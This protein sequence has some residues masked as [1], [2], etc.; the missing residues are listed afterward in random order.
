[1]IKRLLL[2][3]CVFTFLSQ[4][5]VFAQGTSNKDHNFKVAKNLETFSAIYKYLD[6]MYVDT[7]NADEVIGNGINA[8]LSSLDPYTVYYPEDK[9]KE[10][11]MMISGKYAG[12]GA[13]IRYDLKLNNVIIDEPYENM[14]AAEAGLKKGDIIL[15]VNDSS[16]Y[17]KSTS[18]VSDHLRGDAGSTFLLK[19]KRPSTGKTMKFKLTRKAIQ[20]PAVPYYGLQQ[21]GIGYLD[22]NSFTVD[23]SKD[24]RKAFLEMKK[25]GMKSLVLDLRN[26][27]GGSLQE[28]IN[29]VNMFVPKGLVLV[30]TKGKLERANREYKTTVEPIDTLIPIVVLVNDETASASEITS[31]SLQDLDRAV[32]LGTRTYGKGLVQAPMELPYNGNLKLTTSKYYIPS[33]R[34]IQAINYKHSRGGYLEHVPDSLTKVFHTANGRIVRD[35][36]G[37][38]PDVKV[39]PDSLPNIAFYLAN[40]GM[41]S[42][43]VM[44]NWVLNY[45][46][47][48][49]T[50]G[51]PKSFIISDADYEN[52]KSAVIK[53]GFKYDRQS[54]KVIKNLIDIA[55]FEGYYDDAKSEFAAL[56]K[57]LQHNLAKELD[58]HKQTIKQV[59]TADLVAAYYYQRG[60]I[61]NSLQF[62]KQWK[63]AVKLL[64]NPQEYKK[65]LMPKQHN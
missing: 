3:L 9:V 31:G 58:H 59:L 54:E 50:I 43:E 30:N 8:M 28:A 46:K 65:I 57:K 24:V 10:L 55:K 32:I 56:E 25:D 53:S 4:A 19:I 26:N 62:D 12:I 33:G 34:C 11:D 16:M 15:S 61:A 17:K 1:M 14:P 23:C 52:F 21:N 27:G 47:Q 6:L 35:G 45:I 36:G 22:L 29:I 42:T 7:L 20:M 60:A 18:Y 48:H 51:D 39:L 2:C 40:S 63:E 44:T 41:D 37:I 38:N 49:P 64:E 13:L 5:N